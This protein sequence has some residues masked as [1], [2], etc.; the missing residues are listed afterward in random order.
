MLL[1]QKRA[2]ERLR[3]AAERKRKTEGHIAEAARLMSESKAAEALQLMQAVCREYPEET[4]LQKLLATVRESAEREQAEKLKNEHLQKA[5]DALGRQD[6]QAAIA[7]LEAARIDFPSANDVADLLQYAREQQARAE[8]QARAKA[9]EEARA[10]A[11]EEARLKG[12]AEAAARAKA[13]AQAA[14]PRDATARRGR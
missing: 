11:A 6:F 7:T 2:A 10:T 1:Q 3:E 5:K 12:E 14:P 8:E 9:A 13:A 4:R